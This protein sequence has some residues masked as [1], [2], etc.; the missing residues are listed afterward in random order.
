MHMLTNGERVNVS[1]GGAAT[2]YC[3]D[4]HIHV[5]GPGLYIVTTEWCGGGQPL[6]ADSCQQ[7]T[8]NVCKTAGSAVILAP[9]KDKESDFGNIPVILSPRHTYLLDLHPTIQW[10]SVDKAI[11]YEVRLGSSAVKKRKEEITCVEEE[12]AAPNQL[13]SLP[14]PVDWV[15][16]PDNLYTLVVAARRNV[17]EPWRESEPSA[18]YTLD[19]DIAAQLNEDITTVQALALDPTT[20]NLV[21]AGLYTRQQVHSEAIIRYEVI[22]QDAP[23]PA[24]FNTLGDLYRQVELQRYALKAYKAGLDLLNARPD[25][26][27]A[28]AAAEFGSGQAEYSR[29]RYTQAEP[30]FTR[31]AA[32]YSAMPVQE[33]YAA[34]EYALG[35]SS[36]VGEKY[37]EAKQHYSK[38]LEL[39]GTLGLAERVTDVEKA[40]VKMSAR[41]P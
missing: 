34:A 23:A 14:W 40:L 6:P 37:D 19:V 27:A 12:R 20:Q 11:Q 3:V 9:E 16:E 7:T 25:D 17:A 22:L 39:Y 8:G 26:P 24:L 1:A 30:Y 10:V 28:R 2:I 18:L 38:A 36:E 21:L 35:Y 5:V 15:L 31:A 33:E 13:C 41:L 29:L 32:L 4:N